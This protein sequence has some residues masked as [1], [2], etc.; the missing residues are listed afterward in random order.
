MAT[1]LGAS[2]ENSC[3]FRDFLKGDNS[4]ND[5]SFVTQL[6]LI[7]SD[8]QETD[9]FDFGEQIEMQLTVHNTGTNVAQ[10][11]F[12]TTRT[13]DFVVVGQNSDAILWQWSTLQPVFGQTVTTLT[14]QPDETKTFTVT[15]N[16]IGDNG[17]ATNP[18]T[19]RAR[20]V[21]VY[22]GFDVSPL[23]TNNL[24]STPAQFTIR[25]P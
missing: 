22:D 17:V 18:G 13:S 25:R 1:L 21:L 15:W 6:A 4:N 23:Q 10:V 9:T 2:S 12:P 20:G 24:G 3:S 11:D 16:Q 5:Q 14:F 8:G 7:N 19:Y